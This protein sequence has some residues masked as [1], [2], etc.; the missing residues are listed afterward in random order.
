MRAC[1]RERGNC[2][3]CTWHEWINWV[4]HS[5]VWNLFALKRAQMNSVIMRGYVCM[6]LGGCIHIFCSVQNSFQWLHTKVRSM[7]MCASKKCVR[8][9]WYRLRLSKSVRFNECNRAVAFDSLVRSYKLNNKKVSK[10][11]INTSTNTFKCKLKSK[12]LNWL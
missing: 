12:N 7:K 6:W 9:V 11:K 3:K 1:G 2:G 10:S 4:F 8:Y 5:N